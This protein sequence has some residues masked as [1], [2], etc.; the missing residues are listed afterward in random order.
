VAV[1]LGP[2]SWGLLQQITGAAQGITCPRLLWI[3]LPITSAQM[4]FIVVSWA[5]QWFAYFLGYF[6]TH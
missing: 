6:T 3:T 4:E 1:S 5:L 2:D